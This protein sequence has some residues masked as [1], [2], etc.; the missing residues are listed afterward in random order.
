MQAILYKFF[1]SCLIIESVPIFRKQLE[2]LVVY[3]CIL[4]KSGVSK[5]TFIPT[6]YKTFFLSAPF[7]KLQRILIKF[8]NICMFL[9]SLRLK[10]KKLVAD[11][12]KIQSNER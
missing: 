9:I 6:K 7:R 10:M 5:N 1:F 3:I 12:G 2:Q 4:M 11:V 8:W